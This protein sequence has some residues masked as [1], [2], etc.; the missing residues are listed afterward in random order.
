MNSI[1]RYFVLGTLLCSAMIALYWCW[2]SYAV[3]WGY[4]SES[5]LLAGF[6]VHLLWRINTR[7][8]RFLDTIYVAPV[9]GELALTGKDQNFLGM[10]VRGSQ[11]KPRFAPLAGITPYDSATGPP[12]KVQC[13]IG[14]IGQENADRF[15]IPQEDI[16]QSRFRKMAGHFKWE[17]DPFWVDVLMPLLDQE[18]EQNLRMQWRDAPGIQALM[19][20][21]EY[22][23]RCKNERHE[24]PSTTTAPNR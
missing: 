5:R 14:R 18:T 10:Q 13:W 3:R 11:A 24:N 17:T 16:P 23:K 19:S 21:D 12:D 15:N 7:L 1:V 20:E 2:G 9:T 8:E 22:V 6:H 4:Y